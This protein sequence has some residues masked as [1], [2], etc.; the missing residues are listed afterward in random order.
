VTELYVLIFL[1][2]V[3]AYLLWSGLFDLD[4]RYPIAGA[5]LILTVAAFADAA[6]DLKTSGTLVG[7]A[8][9][10]FLG[11]FVLL[12]IDYFRAIRRTSPAFEVP[13]PT[14]PPGSH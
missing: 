6:G 8:L 10:L 13:R 3:G 9:I 4:S 1:P 2:L 12:I 5:F 11:G 7:F 14:N